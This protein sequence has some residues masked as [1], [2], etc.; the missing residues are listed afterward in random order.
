MDEP[1]PAPP[2]SPARLSKTPSWITLGF[3]L[4]A[5]FVLVLPHEPPPAAPPAPPR[6]VKL[7]RPKLTEIE[8]VFA[9]WGDHAVWGHDVTEVALWDMDTHSY[10][11]CYEVL[12]SGDIYFFRS[13]PKLTRPVL[14]HGVPANSPLLFT[15]TEESR[16]EWLQRG[17]YE[18]LAR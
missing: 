11:I 10:S 9:A 6:V 13:I 12:R 17:Q 3:L 4:G 14:T 8:A 7:E 1:E 15:E 5:L 18:S 2:P 16:R